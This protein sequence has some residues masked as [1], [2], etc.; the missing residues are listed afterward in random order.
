M[1]HAIVGRSGRA[2]VVAGGA[3]VA[4][5][6]GTLLAGA[7]AAHAAGSVVVSKVSN[8]EVLV[9]GSEAA[10]I[11]TAR[12]LNGSL[13]FTESRTSIQAGPGCTQVGAVVQCPVPLRIIFEGRG[14]DDAI[15]NFT[16]IRSTIDGFG[17]NDRLTGGSSDD[18]LRGDAG[19]DTVDGRAGRDFCIA[20]SEI[21][22][23]Q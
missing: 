6:V 20:E 3:V 9:R 12:I 14:G 19:N 5:V 15:R 4:A 18:T 17:G 21:N 16:S 13:T 8:S 22:C 10:D 2:R 1:S 23:E 11:T 7:P